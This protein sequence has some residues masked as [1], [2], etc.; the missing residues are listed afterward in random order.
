MINIKKLEKI[1]KEYAKLTGFKIKLE[2]CTEYIYISVT[3]DRIRH[4]VDKITIVELL[5]SSTP[6]TR[7]A[8]FVETTCIT[9]DLWPSESTDADSM[10]PDDGIMRVA[11]HSG[12]KASVEGFNGEYLDKDLTEALNKRF[13]SI[14][15]LL[16]SQK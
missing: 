16:E 1:R 4:W 14:I 3:T 9:A 13:D 8:N 15:Q 2:L 7:F 12:F 11:Y 10:N 5:Q 6:Y